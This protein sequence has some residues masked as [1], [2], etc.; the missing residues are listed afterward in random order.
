MLPCHAVVG[1]TGHAG[2]VTYAAQGTL[3]VNEIRDWN[4]IFL[5]GNVYTK[6]SWWKT[7]NNCQLDRFGSC[8]PASKHGPVLCSVAYHKISICFITQDAGI[9]GGKY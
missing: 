2:A 4:R 1:T 6:L 7:K 8:G 3:I 9:D 5:N